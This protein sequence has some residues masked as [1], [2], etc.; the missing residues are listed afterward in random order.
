MDLLARVRVGDERAAEELFGRYVERL[1]GLAR[2]RLSGRL[3]PRVDPEDVVQSA[4]RSFFSRA[5]QGEYSLSRAGDLWRLL[6]AVTLNKLYRQVQFHSASKRSFR[7]EQGLADDCDLPGARPDF[8]SRDPSPEE[9]VAVVEELERVM[10][11]R[12]PLE[13]RMLEMRLQGYLIDEIAADVG[14]SERT[15]RR[16]L[17]KVRQQLETRL[18]NRAGSA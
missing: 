1:V 3:S 12:D 18:G 14:R 11:G 13:C 9:V 15:V 6:A 10:R 16:L 4:Y 5:R 2:S 17:D 7:R 8:T